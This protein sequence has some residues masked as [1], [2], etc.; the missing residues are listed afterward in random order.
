MK[1]KIAECVVHSRILNDARKVTTKRTAN[2]FFVVTIAVALINVL[3]FAA[4]GFDTGGYHR[5]SRLGAL[6]GEQSAADG[7]QCVYAL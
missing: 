7:H 2:Y 4:F 1:G 3:V 5:S 6:F